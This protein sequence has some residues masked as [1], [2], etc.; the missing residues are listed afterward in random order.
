MALSHS[1]LTLALGSPGQ[2][3]VL[4]DVP[5]QVEALFRFHAWTTMH[6]SVKEGSELEDIQAAG[7]KLSGIWRRALVLQ[8]ARNDILDGRTLSLPDLIYESVSI[9]SCAG[10]GL[11][12]EE[13]E[14]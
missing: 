12:K 9:Y 1:K 11:G 10:R 7:Q 14:N 8:E 13:E 6:P 5:P 4:D 3:G 2:V